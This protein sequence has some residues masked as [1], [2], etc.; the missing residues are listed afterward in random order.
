MSLKSFESKRSQH[1]DN[2]LTFSRQKE[3]HIESD[4]WE[5]EAKAGFDK[6]FFSQTKE[7]QKLLRSRGIIPYREIGDE[8]KDFRPLFEKS[9]MFIHHDNPERVE[10][11]SFYS[12]DSM[13]QAVSAI[14]NSMSVSPH[15]QVRLHFELVKAALKTSDALNGEQLGSL[16]NLTRAGVN[17]RVQR[18]RQVLGMALKDEQE[19]QIPPC[20][21][22]PMEGGGKRVAQHR[23][24]KM[25]TPP[26]KPRG[27]RK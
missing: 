1:L 9:K 16:L 2:L 5:S 10:K 6:W 15:P 12:R 19:G 22:S 11:E 23:E 13:R 26:A 24:R 3:S 14:I 8:R 17:A 4:K 18:M 7:Q 25:R 21:E 27:A 20:K